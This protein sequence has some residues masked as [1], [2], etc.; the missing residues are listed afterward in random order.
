MPGLSAWFEQLTRKDWSDSEISA[1]LGIHQRCVLAYAADNAWRERSASG[2]AVSVILTQLLQ[3]G[4]IDGALV[5]EA[6]VESGIVKNR[7]F[8]AH[9]T[10]ELRRA[11]GSKYQTVHFTSQALPLIRAFEGKLAVV[12]LPCDAAILRRLCEK[13]ETLKAKIHSI[14]TLFCAHTSQPELTK[15]IVDR[16]TAQENLPLTDFH[17]KSGHWRGNMTFTFGPEH[18]TLQI[19]Y[20]RYSL[21]QN[22]FFFCDRKCLNCHDQFGYAGDISAGDIWLESMKTETIKHTA[23][24]ARTNR[25]SQILAECEASGALV[26]KESTANFI[27]QG[28]SRTARCHYNTSARH[29]VGKL[30]G[31]SIPDSVRTRVSLID[32]LI[33]FI[34]LFN[35]RLSTTKLGKKVIF[36]MPKIVWKAYLY[37][38]KA[39]E[40]M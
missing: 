6:Y 21:Y 15:R 17:Y 38:F 29:R 4:Q 20:G 1:M 31:I 30:L 33:A 25:G 7:F 14:I 26:V 28:Q 35:Y 9:T 36:S 32:W 37:F 18:T 27:L 19:P 8:I 16:V 13:E 40:S 5:N 3:S 39:L 12:A 11:Q 2:G 10:D 22:L 34:V 23:L 24:I